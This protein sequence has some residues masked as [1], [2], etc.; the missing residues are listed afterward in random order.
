MLLSMGMT[1]TYHSLKWIP[2]FATLE[3]EICLQRRLHGLNSNFCRAAVIM[4]AAVG[5][6]VG[7]SHWL[8]TFECVVVY[9]SDRYPLSELMDILTANMRDKSDQQMIQCSSSHVRERAAFIFVCVSPNFASGGIILF[10][11][12]ISAWN[13][14]RAESLRGTIVYY[15]ALPAAQL[16]EQWINKISSR[17]QSYLCFSSSISRSSL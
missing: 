6:T 7:R 5:R 9:A 4:Y 14:T 1:G 13:W 17:E 10:W 2:F 15:T 8:S 12:G 16:L 11:L 3:P